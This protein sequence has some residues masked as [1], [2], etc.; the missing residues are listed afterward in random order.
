[1]FNAA[2]NFYAFANQSGNIYRIPVSATPRAT[3]FTRTD[4]AV[5]ND[6]A[7]CAD[8]SIDLDFGDAPDAL[9]T[10]LASDGPRH[11]L[12]SGVGSS[13][14]V[15]LGSTVTSE[16]DAVTPL[17]GL[18]DTDEGTSTLSPIPLNAPIYSVTL[19]ATNS[20]TAT[21]TVAGWIDFNSNNAFLTS[22]SVTTNERATATVS[23]GWINVPVVLTWTVPNTVAGLTYARFRIST[24]NDDTDATTG[25]QGWATNPTPYNDGRALEN[26]EVEDYQVNIFLSVSGNV[27]N[28]TDGDNTVDGTGVN[29]PSLPLYVSLVQSGT[30]VATVPVSSTG[31]YSFTAV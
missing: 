4:P 11:S 29:G 21:A 9:N 7:R 23:A 19:T 16:P 22:A 30:I 26:G 6:G 10:T 1:M 31:G 20:T 28:D 25:T 12:S 27:F 3:L 14:P 24:D 13:A 17:L 15:R 18:S 8:A 2:N 5:N